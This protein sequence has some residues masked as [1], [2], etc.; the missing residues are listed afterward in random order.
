MGAGG[1]G[2]LEVHIDGPAHKG[3]ERQL[4]NAG[5]VVIVVI[6]AFTVGAQVAGQVH[7]GVEVGDRS[8]G[9]ETVEVAAAAFS[10]GVQGFGQVDDS[11]SAHFINSFHDNSSIF[12]IFI[13]LLFF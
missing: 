11:Q 5:P 9:V 1:D 2:V 6:G 10:L 7:D 12:F 3:G 4:G 8:A 13:L